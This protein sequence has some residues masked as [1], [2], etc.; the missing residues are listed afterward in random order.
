MLSG[1]PN[2]SVY[3]GQDRFLLNSD[4]QVG[5]EILTAP[6]IFINVGARAIVPAIQG[7]GNLTYFTNSSILETHF[8][9]ESLIVGER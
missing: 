9:P 4:V 1:A 3:R 2:C 7:P 8:L 5:E 6:Q